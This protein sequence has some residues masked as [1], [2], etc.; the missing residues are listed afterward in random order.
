MQLRD[1]QQECIDKIDSMPPGSYLVHMATGLGKTVTF[2]NAHRQ[3][4]MLILS[5]REELVRQPLKYFDCSTGVEMAE[6]H[7]NGEEVISASVQSLVRRLDRFRPDDFDI[8]ITDECQHAASKTYRT[9]FSYFHPR[10]HLGF[11]ATPRRADNVR[12]DDV[13]SSIIFSRDLRWGI[14]HHYL[15]D[16][17]ARR[18]YIGYDLQGVHT[19]GGDYAPGELE[20]AM[21][22]TADAIAEAYQT[23][24][25]GATLIF[26]VSVAQAEE[27]ASR[28]PGA[29]AVTGTTAGRADIIQRFTDGEIPCIVNVMVFTEGTDIP[30]VET[31]IIARPT[32]SESLYA[33]MVGRGLR[34][35]PG[36]ERLELIDCVGVTGRASLCTAPSLLGIDMSAIPESRRK[37]VQGE[38]F[39]LPDKA[40]RAQDCP[41]SWIRNVRT[42]DLWAKAQRF[43]T[44][45]VNWFQ[46]PDG[47]MTLSVQNRIGD[48]GKF[49][50]G[51]MNELGKARYNGLIMPMQDALDQA[52]ETLRDEWADAEALWSVKAME[53]WGAAP[54][55]DR[56]KELIR[57][58]LRDADSQLN[59]GELTKGDASLIL[60]RLLAGRRR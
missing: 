42:V 25:K 30:R 37:D 18:A 39:E 35:Y 23:L 2:A 55:S 47:S 32:K 48:R 21:D 46:L 60:N 19:R 29:V 13:Y 27:I 36:K 16:I 44:H 54:A 22:G 52:F 5:H 34:L 6:E 9:I 20:Q 17:Y 14:E 51:P 38:L 10:L 12:L 53:R 1:Y 24:A 45:G 28:I 3:G 33:Q 26:A 15:S 31:V 4:R 57:K 40:V 11:T 56:Q 8:I 43:D 58:K 59:M 49:V 7:S 50:I 41:Q